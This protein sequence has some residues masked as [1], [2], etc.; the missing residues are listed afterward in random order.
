[1]PSFLKI[2]YVRLPQGGRRSNS[3]RF[4]SVH[5]STNIAA[6]SCRLVRLVENHTRGNCTA[7]NQCTC[8]CWA[9]FDVDDC[10]NFQT[11]C[12]G[13][14]QVCTTLGLKRSYID[15][16]GARKYE[17]NLDRLRQYTV[18]FR[19][20]D[21]IPRVVT[22]LGTS[23]ELQALYSRLSETFLR[24]VRT[25]HQDKYCFPPSGELFGRCAGSPTLRCLRQ[26]SPE[27]T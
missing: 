4:H 26:Q 13:P 7:P 21:Q 19:N 9:E 23:S 20:V 5:R 1:M 18:K 10:A 24:S 6:W 2:T 12:D 3:H 17:M 8:T 15:R 11:N 14:W 22:R 25:T 16:L 27:K